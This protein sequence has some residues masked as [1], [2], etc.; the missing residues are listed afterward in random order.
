MARNQKNVDYIKKDK[1]YWKYDIKA[2]C[3][4]IARENINGIFLE[5]I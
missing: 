3:E 5:N 1:I 4:F 2:L